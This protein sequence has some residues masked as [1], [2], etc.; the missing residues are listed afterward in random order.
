MDPNSQDAIRET[1]RLTRE[2]NQILHSMR[3][4]AFL[5][6]V[7]RFML[8]IIVFAA[9]IWFYMTYMSNSV[10]NLVTALNK[11]QGTSA[12]VQPK[13][14]GVEDAIKNIEA[15]LPGFNAVATTTATTT[16]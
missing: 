6:G 4:S 3:R 14:S 9:P 16:P 7:I 1:L 8:Y 15:H 5:G 11:I 2:N 13:F 12:T 10:D